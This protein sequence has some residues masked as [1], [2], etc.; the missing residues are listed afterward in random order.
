MDTS[1]SAGIKTEM[2]Q[3]V[4]T[5]KGVPVAQPRHRAACRG[6]FPKLYIPKDHAVHEWRR[7]IIAAAAK[8]TDITI[9]GAIKVDCLFVFPSPKSKKTQT[10]N[11]KFSKPDIDN[12]LKAVFDALT[13]VSLWAD[14]SQVVEV[15]SAKMYGDEPSAIIRVEAIDFKVDLD[16][17]E[18]K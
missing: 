8:V 2:P 9:E 13:E 3:I 14:D 4:F 6:G 10:G 18:T 15:H 7:A 11:Y 17:V 16:A 12:L 1:T 5:V